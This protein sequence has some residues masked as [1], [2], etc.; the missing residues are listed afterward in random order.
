[1]TLYYIAEKR[2]GT[3]DAGSKAR[4]DVSYI[5]GSKKWNPCYVTRTWGASTFV[6]KMRAG[7][8]CSYE[9]NGIA[10]RLHRHDVLLLQ[11]PLSVNPQVART[12]LS[13]IRKMHQCGV[14]L[15]YLIHDLD[16]FRGMSGSI[17]RQFI[18]L[19]DVAIAH[20][21][22]MSGYLEENYKT[23]KTV[24]LGIFDYILPEQTEL[25]DGLRE[26][27]D[28]AG[29]LSHEKAG[30]LYDDRLRE[31]NPPLNLYGPNYVQDCG[32][33]QYKGC[34]PADC[35]PSVLTGRFG[36]VW[37]GESP[38]VCAGLSGEY[39]KINNP[40]KLSLYLACGIPVFIWDQAAEA[41]FVRTNDIGVAVSSIPDAL[42]EY[43]T[44]T[45]KRYDTLVSNAK[46]VG[47]KLQ[48]GYYTLKAVDRA[49]DFI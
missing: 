20:N 19:A 4:D 43:R 39:L 6:E 13:S 44:I 47:K 34:F 41:E 24:S 42:K 29:N 1:M 21:E 25:Y 35:L 49:L 28:V 17:E 2:G 5:L 7:V 11:Y 37:D 15:I 33:G 12:A 46:K 22:T 30:Y 31:L 10:R 3:Y 16:S 48:S 23:I 18:E 38:E 9:W 40:H 32:C 27:I 8:I 45:L 36:L 26:G 14:K